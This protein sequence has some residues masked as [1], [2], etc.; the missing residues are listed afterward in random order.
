MELECRGFR[1][2]DLHIPP[3]EVSTHS[4]VFVRFPGG[5]DDVMLPELVRILAGENHHPTVEVTGS[6][7]IAGRASATWPGVDLPGK[8]TL[9]E[10][11][12]SDLRHLPLMVQRVLADSNRETPFHSDRRIESTGAGT[13]SLVSLRIQLAQH[14]VVLFTTAGSDPWNTDACRQTVKDGPTFGFSACGIEF[15]PQGSPEPDERWADCK[16]VFLARTGPP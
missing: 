10:W 5:P 2:G 3:F 1:L 7:G 15:I 16:Q 11:V 9:D 13:V 14:N 8:G 6:A 12:R 4:P